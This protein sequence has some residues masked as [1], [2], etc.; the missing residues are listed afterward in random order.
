MKHEGSSGIECS[1][2]GRKFEVRSSRQMWLEVL[3]IPH[4][5]AARFS[6]EHRW[7]GRLWFWVYT[8]AHVALSFPWT[9]EEALKLIDQARKA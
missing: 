1:I 6:G 9:N 5:I 7:R 2:C 3:M 8:E 4:D